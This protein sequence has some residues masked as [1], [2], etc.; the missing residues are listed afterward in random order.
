[1]SKVRITLEFDYPEDSK[2]NVSILMRDALAEFIHHRLL[3]DYVLKRYPSFEGERRVM[4]M[5]QVRERVAIAEA[6]YQGP[7]VV[8]YEERRG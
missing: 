3:P 6:I 4:K 5:E 7:C 8:E 2:V 1:M